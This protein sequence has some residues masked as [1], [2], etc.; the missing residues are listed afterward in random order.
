MDTSYYKFIV[1]ISVR[2][3]RVFVDELESLGYN[4][5]FN[6]VELFYLMARNKPILWS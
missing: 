2:G 3:F 5:D 4:S 6:P 1:V